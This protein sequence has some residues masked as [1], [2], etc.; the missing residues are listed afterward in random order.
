MRGRTVSELADQLGFCAITSSHGP[1][2]NPRLCSKSESSGQAASSIKT[3]SDVFPSA[4]RKGAAIIP[5]LQT[6]KRRLG[7]KQVVETVARPVSLAPAH[8]APVQETASLG[9]LGS[10][11]FWRSPG[12]PSSCPG[13]GSASHPLLASHPNSR[14]N[15][16]H[17]QRFPKLLVLLELRPLKCTS[18]HNLRT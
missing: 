18:V 7:G 4:E 13:C 17:S 11:T 16:A 9:L 3:H 5:S 10:D 14:R 6:G 2:P 12:S 1:S 15:S 8:T